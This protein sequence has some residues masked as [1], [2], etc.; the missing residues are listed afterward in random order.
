MQSTD[1]RFVF[2]CLFTYPWPENLHFYHSPPVAL[3]MPW[4]LAPVEEILS[5]KVI[6][7]VLGEGVLLIGYTSFYF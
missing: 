4:S 2:S 1:S 3:M 6:P 5:V 7:T